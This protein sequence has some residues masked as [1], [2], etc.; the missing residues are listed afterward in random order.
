MPKLK[1][2]IQSKVLS[3]AGR[4]RRLLSPYSDLDHPIPPEIVDD[5]FH[6]TIRSLAQT[7][8]I[9]TILEIGSSTGE[10]ST[11]AFVDGIRVNSNRPL[12]FCLEA[13]RVRFRRLA[14]RYAQEPQVKCYNL[15]SVPIGR[16]PTEAQVAAFHRDRRSTLNS[17]SLTEVI[18][19]LHQDMRYVNGLGPALNGIQI[20]KEANGV[21][22]FGMVLIDGSE[23][24]GGAELDEIYGADYILLDDIGSFKNLDNYERL[25]SDPTYKLLVSNMSLRSGY[26]VFERLDH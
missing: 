25:R 16:F 23:F 22:R 6:E 24:T 13:S 10:G 4:L 19:W 5:E 2:M 9:Q 18:R 20:I 8:T 15:T 11:R 7:A 12:L 17:Y 26:A 1:R 21:D 3:G 14:R